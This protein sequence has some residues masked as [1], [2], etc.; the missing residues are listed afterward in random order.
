MVI[1]DVSDVNDISDGFCRKFISF[2]NGKVVGDAF[3]C[4]TSFQ[5]MFETLK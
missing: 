1:G 4:L 3:F 5:Y 2:Y